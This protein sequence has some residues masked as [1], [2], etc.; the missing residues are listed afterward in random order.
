M[1]YFELSQQPVIVYRGVKPM[2]TTPMISIMKAE[3]LM[4]CGCEAYLAFVTTSVGNKAKLPEI[5]VVCEFPYVFL[6]ELPGLPPPREV[7]F[8]IDL[9]PGTQPISKAP[10]RMAPNVLK[11][12]KAQLQELI[13]KGFIRPSVLPWGAP[14]LFV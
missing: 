11:E 2:S 8:F 4:R 13:D 10:Y 7:E 6:D 5:L 12:L 1:I 9:I 14:V 3:Q